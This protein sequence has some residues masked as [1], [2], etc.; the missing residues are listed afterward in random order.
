MDTPGLKKRFHALNLDRMRRIRDALSWKQR[1]FLDAL[2]LLFHTNYLMFPGYISQSTP[3]GVSDF[4]PSRTNI[5]AA[6]KITKAY[7][8]QKEVKA[9]IDIY[10]IFL[11][12]SAGTVAYSERSDFDIWLCHRPGLT[13]D[14]IDELNQKSKAI[15][16]WAE[17]VELD[18][19]FF[20][21]DADEFKRG[22]HLPLSSESSGST[23]HS[24]LLDEFYRTSL[25]I[26]GRYP[27]WW[28]VPSSKEKQYERYIDD[29]KQSNQIQD[30]ETID[31]GHLAHIP[32]EEFF[33]ASL[34]QLYKGI[35]S[36]HK[37]VLKLLL[38]Q[39]YSDEFP[40]INLLSLRFKELMHEDE[41]TI[42]RVDPYIL[43]YKKIDEYL[44]NTD[45][46]RRLELYRRC[47]YLKVNTSLSKPTHPRKS[48]WRREIM[49]D[50]VN[51]WGWSQNHLQNLDNRK[52]W[53]V[54][55]V[56]EERKDLISELI[57]GYQSLSD[58]ARSHTNDALINQDD[59][60]I[61]GRKL[62]AAFERKA[63]K[64][65]VINRG[66]SDTK[67]QKHMTLVQAPGHDDIDNWLLYPDIVSEEE[68]ANHT[69]LKRSQSLIELLSWCHFNKLTDSHTVFSLIKKNEELTN[70]EVRAI[71]ETL[72]SLFPGGKL[73]EPT[74]ED[75]TLPP[76]I[77]TVG[78]FI[79]V[80][81]DP[82]ASWTRKGKHL[83]SNRTNAFSYGGN[84]QNL[85]QT[86]DLVIATSWQETLTYRYSGASGLM[87]CLCEYL[88]WAPISKQV[89]PAPL[90]PY[91]FSSHLGRCITQ[92]IGELCNDLV[93][94][95]YSGTRPPS[96]RYALN[97]GN[98]YFVLQ[99]ADDTLKHYDYESFDAFITSLGKE[100][101]NF[102]PV[103][104]DR[105]TLQ[106]T[107]LP[108]VFSINKPDKIQVLFYL[109]GKDIDIY[110]VDEKGSLFSQRMPYSDIS[111][112]LHHYQVFLRSV[113]KR[114]KFLMD[115]VG[116]KPGNID[117]EFYQIIKPL[118]GHLTIRKYQIDELKPSFNP[119]DIQVI[120]DIDID[121]NPVFSIYFKYYEF[122]SLE[123]GN[124]VFQAAAEY[125]LNQRNSGD[126]YPV[127]ITDLDLSRTLLSGQEASKYQTIHFL[128]YKRN[129]ED[130][131]TNALNEISKAEIQRPSKTKNVA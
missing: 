8:H 81:K 113:V 99:F 28:L 109:A 7:D 6:R 85:A 54:S 116:D 73:H 89:A 38:L 60:N 19:H 96:T 58:F 44:N 48:D 35:S 112:L 83:T 4:T 21:F 12:G 72:E 107:P 126:S 31:F 13:E 16:K 119:F 70:K 91:S 105:H 84:H 59:L 10:S 52:E 100:Q 121:D 94:C 110:I 88:R 130:K 97:I 118:R 127:Y 114:R 86:F 1:I 39:I 120:G 62:Y 47:F 71:S 3:S 64:I 124:K 34:W 125:V 46:S 45:E 95:Y 82:M 50:L 51:S 78:I 80:G 15:E 129:I 25:L 20:V 57:K 17:D 75:L 61:L 108:L 14:Q 122:S 111:R 29:L 37:S 79:N 115:G 74:T 106:D 102:S 5:N 63:G 117:I 77:Q 98:F 27:V 53:S 87:D 55:H 9:T 33:S 131:L 123:Y 40:N 43:M 11:M 128:T 2:P 22:E 93:Q 32:V 26:A 49:R 36:P 69:P 68:I 18:V 101:P 92:R 67:P 24:L 23:Q 30:N 41:V 65:E 56:L 103:V 76:K 90:S 66:H 42:D 104:I